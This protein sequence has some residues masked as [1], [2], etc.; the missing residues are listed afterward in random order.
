MCRSVF[1]RLLNGHG[2]SGEIDTSLHSH[3]AAEFLEGS[4]GSST[5]GSGLEDD[6]QLSKV[7]P[8]ARG[9]GGFKDYAK[10][11]K[12]MTK[13]DDASQTDD[14]EFGPSQIPSENVRGVWRGEARGQFTEVDSAA[15][16]RGE[17]GHARGAGAERRSGNRGRT[18]EWFK[19]HGV[20]DVS[21]EFPDTAKPS[22]TDVRPKQLSAFK[23]VTDASAHGP[24]DVTQVRN[25]LFINPTLLGK[26]YTGF[27]D[28]GPAARSCD[29]T[30][31]LVFPVLFTCLRFSQG[32]ERRSDW[33]SHRGEFHAWLHKENH[34][35]AEITNNQRA[36]STKE[37]KIRRSTLKVVN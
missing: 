12:C 24:T 27:T 35:L 5:Q 33:K 8:M 13:H 2:A 17:G 21:Y 30:P 16:G 36:L 7:S 31:H 10:H 29:K 19:G 34:K 9:S 1:L 18:R 25:S 14:A 6:R 11:G 15:I 22:N 28:S 26:L 4:A 37:L 32:R 3:H 20:E 23:H